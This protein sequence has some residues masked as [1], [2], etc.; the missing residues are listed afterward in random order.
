MML[1]VDDKI[2]VKGGQ[3]KNEA[4]VEN[5]IHSSSGCKKLKDKKDKRKYFGI[6]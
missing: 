1:K 5:S 3:S 2:D 6:W 4:I